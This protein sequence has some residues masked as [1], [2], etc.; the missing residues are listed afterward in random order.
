MINI[1]RNHTLCETYDIL[2]SKKTGCKI[3]K[4]DIDNYYDSTNYMKEKIYIKFKDE[5]IG[6][7][8]KKFK[9][10]DYKEIFNNILDNSKDKKIINF[11]RIYDERQTISYITLFTV[12]NRY[13]YYGFKKSKIY[14]LY[15]K[16]K[17]LNLLKRKLY[18]TFDESDYKNISEYIKNN[19]NDDNVLNHKKIEKR[20]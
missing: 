2:H 6:K 3:C 20:N 8:K 4:L 7:I 18:I 17:K 15:N 10:H 16:I 19:K 5:L 13:S 1:K 12:G 9:K 11:K 14:D